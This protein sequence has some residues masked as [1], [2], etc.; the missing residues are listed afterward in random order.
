MDGSTRW[1]VAALLG[2]V[3]C[4]SAAGCG[5]GSSDAPA[6]A[7]APAVT[8]SP[9]AP[10]S[11]SPPASEPPA[12]APP[13]ALTPACANFYSAG[14]ALSGTRTTDSIAPLAKPVKGVAFAEPAYGTCVVRST[15]HVSDGVAGFTRNDYSRRQAFNATG[16]HY[17]AYALNGSWHLYETATRQRVKVLPGPGG[18]AEP[19]W[20]ATDGDKL[21]YLPTNGVGMKVNELTVSTGATRVVGDLGARLK[22]R[23]PTAAVAWTKS[24]GAP[25]RDQ[26][27]WCFMVEDVNFGTLGVATWDR[28]ADSLVGTMNTNG[29][30]PDHVSMSPSGDW[31]V[32]SGDG[33]RGTVA[34]S[35]DFSQ[36]R[37]LLAKSEHSDLA[38]AAN[39]D[40]LYVSVDYQS[41]QGDLFM[42]NLRTGE[43]T[44]LLPTY[45]AGTTNA[46]HISGKGYDK[47]GWVIVSVYAGDIPAGASRQWMHDKVFAM[48]LKASPRTFNLAFHRSVYNA[49]WTE[50]HATVSRDFTKVLFNS[51]W[52]TGSKEDVDAYMVELPAD[53][54]K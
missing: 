21:Y 39:G 6:N 18:D 15:D 38:V 7:A 13:S 43:R 19:Q 9:P 17:L 42:I 2:A 51:N 5:G 54:V 46:L 29:D 31:C 32:V 52:H 50:P 4:L 10:V 33:A 26:R 37:K 36:Q 8:P 22:A 16:T 45:L 48:E 41:A 23:W 34:Y 12:A 11:P 25:S 53:A 24:E 27:Y 35:R 14:F 47:P 30:R 49:Y 3:A 28:E 20:H 1:R 44:A 40:D